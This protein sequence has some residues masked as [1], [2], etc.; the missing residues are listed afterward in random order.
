[1]RGLS[2]INEGAGDFLPCQAIPDSNMD[3][4]VQ[5]IET[6]NEIEI[7]T[8]PCRVMKLERL[9]H[10][11][12][13]VGLKTPDNNR[14]KFMPGQYIDFLLRDGRRR[15]FS[16]A[17]APHDDDL[18]QLHIRHVPNGFFTDHIFNKMKIKDLM[19]IEAPLGSFF[20]R[21]SSKRPLL[22]IAGGTGFAPIKSI[23]E[24]ALYIGDK[25]PIHLYWGVRAKRDLYL[26]DLAQKWASH[27]HITYT[28]ILS[29]PL[30]DDIW[31]GKTGFVHET[32]LT[33]KLD[34]PAM[35][36]YVCAPPPMVEAVR[37]E[38][39]MQ[40]LAKKHFFADSFEFASDTTSQL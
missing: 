8:V 38:L 25:R 22:M 31:K 11:V 6:V 16:L 9:A 37:S 32:L 15:S 35:D 2:K 36:A 40:G 20:L 30:E 24:H 29:T 5:E 12:M 39:L 34:V 23:I 21:E 26:H 7:K 14:L 27:E 10:D 33:E 17:N 18:L 28:P 1:M 3:I 19:R 4:E 13:L